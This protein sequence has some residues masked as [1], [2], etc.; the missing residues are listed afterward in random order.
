MEAD[1]EERDQK[2]LSMEADE[3]EREEEEVTK[4]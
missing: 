2:N 3:E 4:M 1:G